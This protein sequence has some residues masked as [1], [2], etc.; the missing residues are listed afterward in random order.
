MTV[1]GER[2]EEIVNLGLR[3]K[4][5]EIK[6]KNF[7]ETGNFGFGIE[8][9]IDMGVKYDPSVG[10]YGMDFYVVLRRAGTRVAKRK[11]K[12]GRVGKNQKI[13][14]E[15]AIAWVKKTFRTAIL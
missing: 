5:F 7:S 13:S 10:I 8:E 11:A 15:E 12:R 4:D 2:A 1:R 14:K 3:V 6:T 9:H